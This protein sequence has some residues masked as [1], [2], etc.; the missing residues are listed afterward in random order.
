VEDGLAIAYW[1]LALLARSYIYLFLNTFAIIGFSS[2]K[3]NILFN[4]LAFLGGEGL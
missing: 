1:L 3:I 2:N 4:I